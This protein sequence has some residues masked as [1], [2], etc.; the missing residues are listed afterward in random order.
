MGNLIVTSTSIVIPLITDKIII[1]F[2]FYPTRW[3]SIPWKEPSMFVTGPLKFVI[4]LVTLSLL[5][6]VSGMMST[7]K[8]CNKKD[9]L[10]SW[11]RSIW[12]ILGY[13]IGNMVV[14]LLPMIK[15]PILMAMMWMPYAG[16]IAHGM[17]VSLFIMFFGAM[18]NTKLRND[19][20]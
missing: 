6:A 1:P 18:G 19:V 11:K 13:L 2:V 12:V 5:A 16:Y 3:G 4:N 7:T 9:F 15:A 14:T 10:L 17:L 20:C 8:E